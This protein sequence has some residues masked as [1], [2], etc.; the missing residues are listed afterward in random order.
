ML[1]LFD[2]GL[3][4][5]VPA[6]ST[7]Y[8][9][10]GTPLFMAPEVLRKRGHNL[11]VD[12]WAFGCVVHAMASGHANGPFDDPST[13]ISDDDVYERILAVHYDEAALPEGVRGLVASLLREKPDE[14]ASW[15]AVRADDFFQSVREAWGEERWDRLLSGGVAAPAVASSQRLKVAPWQQMTREARS[16]AAK[17]GLEGAG[18]GAGAGDVVEAAHYLE[19]HSFKTRGRMLSRGLHHV[20]DEPWASSHVQ[21]G[22]GTVPCDALSFEKS[23]RSSHRR[24]STRAR[25]EHGDATPHVVLPLVDSARGGESPQSPYARRLQPMAQADVAQAVEVWREEMAARVAARRAAVQQSKSQ[26]SVT[27]PPR[28]FTRRLSRRPSKS[29]LTTDRAAP[30]MLRHLLRHAVA[31]HQNKLDGATRQ[32]L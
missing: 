5:V 23:R 24:L 22:G 20:D 12:S 26:L 18:A 14:R 11:P 17:V 30:R 19:D 9:L 27:T 15:A 3:A 28:S 6:Q 31:T 7:T 29:T 25:Q 13:D 10:C 8:T 16:D 21:S 1:K 32:S 4:K 2:F